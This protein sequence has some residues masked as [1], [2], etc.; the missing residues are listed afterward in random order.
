MESSRWAN[1]E[2]LSL[3]DLRARNHDGSGK[4]SLQAQPTKQ[5]KS[6]QQAPTDPSNSSLKTKS[7][8][9]EAS[10]EVDTGAD[11]R[12]AALHAELETIKRMNGVI[13]GVTASLENAK[14][15]M[16]VCRRPQSD[17]TLVGFK[18]VICC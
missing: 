10:S 18:F 14:S 15:N 3:S 17:G 5:P 4:E 7:R 13:E 8:L 12:E 11:S 16:N 9:Q 6:M 1:M 2:N